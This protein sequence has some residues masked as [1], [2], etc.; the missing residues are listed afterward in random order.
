MKE[1][2]A[3]IIGAGR[4]GSAFALDFFSKGIEIE[5]IVDCK[6]NKAKKLASSVK[7]KNYTDKISQISSSAN[8]FV[9]TVQDRFI[10]QVSEE[11]ANA[12]D[13]F[14]NK[15][16]FHSSGALDANELSSLRN[17]K[18]LTFTFHPNFS[19]VDEQRHEG[20]LIDFNQCYFAIESNSKKAITFAKSFCKRLNYNFVVLTAK[21]K[22]LYHIFSV[23]ISNYTVTEFYL[24]EKFF[25]KKLINSYLNLLKSTIQNIEEYGAR[26]ALT[27]P[28]V[29]NDVETIKKHLN[30]LSQINPKMKEL[31][32]KFGLLTLEILDGERNLKSLEDLK[33]I[34]DK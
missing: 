23:I 21:E 12:F 17:K 22:V 14:E 7:A 33:D 5:T 25:G 1:I 10:K 18:C 20:T 19:F 28:I 3:A 31:Y 32:K 13:T 2:K 24:V 29:R 15:F 4:V 9:I 8:L 6:L 11:L 34:F 30:V 27:G 16:A 26:K